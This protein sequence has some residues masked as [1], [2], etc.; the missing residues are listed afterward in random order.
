MAES[1]LLQVRGLGHSFGAVKVLSNVNLEVPH[2][3]L[4]GL[5]GPN[6]SGKTTL[7]NLISGYIHPLAGEVRFD[8]RCMAGVPVEGRSRGGLVRTF[9]TPRVFESMTVLENIMAGC[10][11]TEGAGMLAEMLALPD[12]RRARRQMQEAASEVCARFELWPLRNAPTKT[13]PAG[14]RRV[15][16]IARAVVGKPRL[17][18]LDEPSSGLNDDEVRTLEHWIGQLRDDGIAILLVSHDMELM[19]SV[20]T[21]HLLYNGELLVSGDMASLQNDSRVRDVYLGA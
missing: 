4:V 7:F 20:D 12:A 5:I 10:A 8:G 6:G 13:L 2:G 19:G 15:L 1:A 9:Q 16:E 11:K 14:Q 18:M 17:L 21:A 3:G